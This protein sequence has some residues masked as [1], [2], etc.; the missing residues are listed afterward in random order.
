MKSD[1]IRHGS[2]V[3]AILLIHFNKGMKGSGKGNEEFHS[4]LKK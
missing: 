2:V 4:V 3:N 1:Q